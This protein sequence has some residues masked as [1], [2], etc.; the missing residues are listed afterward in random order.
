MEF[1]ALAVIDI[2]D[3]AWTWVGSEVIT[4]KAGKPVRVERWQRPCAVCHKAYIAK[5]KM[6]SYVAKAYELRNWPGATKIT[7]VVVRLRGA[8]GNFA[9]RTCP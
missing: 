5:Q 7:P 8:F 4:N 2:R 9:I 6:P 3:F 1:H